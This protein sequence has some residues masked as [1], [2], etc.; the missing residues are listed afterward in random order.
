MK[1][2][3]LFKNRVHACFVVARRN[4]LIQEKS[5]KNLEILWQIFLYSLASLA[6][7]YLEI[8]WRILLYFLAFW[9]WHSLAPVFWTFLDLAFG[10]WHLHHQVFNLSLLI[11][12]FSLFVVEHSRS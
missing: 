6:I 7:A 12:S 8:L 9:Q 2:I 1:F 10:H 4:I 3:H 11:L 5:Y